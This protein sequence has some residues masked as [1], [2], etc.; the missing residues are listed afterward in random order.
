M[1]LPKK[2]NMSKHDIMLIIFKCCV[3]K[4]YLILLLTNLKLT[5]V[6]ID[7]INKFIRAIY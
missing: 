6:Q 7:N 3:Y 4:F 1:V 5:D 2:E